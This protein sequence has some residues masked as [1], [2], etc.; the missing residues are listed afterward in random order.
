MSTAARLGLYAGGLALVLAGSAAV[1]RA[2]VPEGTVQAWTR[3]A[4]AGAGDMDHGGHAAPAEAGGPRGTALEQ[5]GY[6]LGPVTAPDRVGMAGRLAFRISTADGAPLTR[7]VESHDRELHLIVVRSDGTRFRH[8][9]PT[10]TPDGTWSLPWTWRAA[11]TYRVFADFVPA[12]VPDAPDVTV[13]RTVE[14]AGPYTPNPP[15]PGS[16]A[17]ATTAS[18]DGFDVRLDGG[19][20]AGLDARLTVTVGREGKPVTTL[21]PYLGA[22][23]HLVVLREGDLAYLHVHPMGDEPAP[24]QVSGPEIAFMS[25]A[26]TP[27][28]YLLYLDF[29]V[30]DQ[31]HTATFVLDTTEPDRDHGT[32]AAQVGSSTSEQHGAGE[33]HGH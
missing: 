24:G 31:V 10:L 14:V 23:G 32:V 33:E 30:D 15:V 19:L 2:V 26:P 18:V 28:R 3:A 29:Q 17:V 13:S 6:R 12:D 5:D 22:F 16:G 1:G 20:Q 25:R 7:Y 27:G 11:G 8:V 21:Q 4:Q 9:H